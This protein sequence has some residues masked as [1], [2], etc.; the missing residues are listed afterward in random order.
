[1]FWPKTTLSVIK[2]FIYFTKLIN[3][4]M[5]YFL[6]IMGRREIGLRLFTAFSFPG[7][8]NGVTFPN[9]HVSGISVEV[10]DILNKSTIFLGT[11][12]NASLNISLDKNSIQDD[13]LI[14]IFL[15]RVVTSSI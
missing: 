14:L 1:M 9:F 12:R 11:A 3:S 4:I 15:Q 7:F 5:Y 13:L 10:K 8:C 6:E 2:D